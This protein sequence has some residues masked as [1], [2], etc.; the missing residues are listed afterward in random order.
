VEQQLNEAAFDGNETEVRK[1]LKENPSTNVNWKDSGLAALH[2]ASFSGHDKVVELLLAHP[3][4]DVNQKDESSETPFYSACAHGKIACV[5]LLLKDTRVLVNEPR[6]SGQ[7]P[8]TGPAHYG[9]IELIKAWIASGREMNLGKPGNKY[10][11]AIGFAR[12]SGK[13]D[14]VTLLEKFKANPEQTRAEVRGGDVKMED[15]GG[16]SNTGVRKSARIATQARKG[17]DEK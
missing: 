16:P 2:L 3:D 13:T 14:V 8:L 1:I 9:Y 4:I 5:Q 17:Q 6:R 11:D 10:T 12:R 7:T 15:M